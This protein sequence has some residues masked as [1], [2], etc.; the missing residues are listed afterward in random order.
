MPDAGSILAI[1]S[2]E[3]AE[4]LGIRHEGNKTLEF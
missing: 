1:V 4:G 2:I 3:L